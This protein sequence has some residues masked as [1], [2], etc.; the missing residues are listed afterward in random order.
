MRVLVVDDD[1]ILVRSVAQTLRRASMDVLTATGGDEAIQLAARHPIDVAVLDLMM[2]RMNGIE[3]IRALEHKTPGVRIVLTSSF[4]LSPGQID[5]MGLSNV[6][7][8]TKPAAPEEL[9]EAV[10]GSRPIETRAVPAPTEGRPHSPR[11]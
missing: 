10:R 7:F 6:K 11:H 3:V 1:E 8:L 5:R 4:P 2:P 9:L